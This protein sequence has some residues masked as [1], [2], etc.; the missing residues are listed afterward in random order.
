M[1]VRDHDAM[2]RKIYASNSDLTAN[3]SFGYM[4]VWLCP[5]PENRAV[6]LGL[7]PVHIS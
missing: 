1:D 4:W 6:V 5:A 7:P 3:M 2:Q